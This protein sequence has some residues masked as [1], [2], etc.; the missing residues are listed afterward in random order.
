[1]FRGLC[2][3]TVLSLNSLAFASEI[4][5]PGPDASGMWSE[6]AKIGALNAGT[7]MT[8]SYD[9]ARM[10]ALGV[11]RGYYRVGC[12]RSVRLH[13][14][15][16]LSDQWQSEYL[17]EQIVSPSSECAGQ[18][19]ISQI[20]IDLPRNATR[21]RLYFHGSSVAG[22][23]YDSNFGQDFEFAVQP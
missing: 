18:D 2:I 11:G 7:T 20:E 8:I 5:F 19:G 17:Q 9:L 22:S 4:Q 14:Q 6:P 23:A 21:I 13:A 1:M 10:D 3:A 12:T 15:I 16:S